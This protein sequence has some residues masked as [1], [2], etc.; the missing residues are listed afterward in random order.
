MVR[1]TVTQQEVSIS[2]EARIESV[3]SEVRKGVGDLSDQ[4]R[5]NL[6]NTLVEF[7]EAWLKPQIGKCTKHVV[8]LD[9]RGDPIRHPRP[10]SPPLTEELHKQIDD[11]AAAGVRTRDD[12]NEWAAPVSLVAKKQSGAWRMI[13][14]MSTLSQLQAHFQYLYDP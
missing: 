12:N 10:L 6:V 11:L 4:Q 8:Q 5:E 3:M 13:Y 2:E 7:K 9:I 14:V 1:N